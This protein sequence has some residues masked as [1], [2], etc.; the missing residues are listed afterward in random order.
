MKADDHDIASIF[1]QLPEERRAAMGELRQT[2]VANLPE[3]F[4]ESVNKSSIAYVV[5]LSV[6]PPGYH[7]NPKQPLPFIDISSAKKHIALYHMG[8]YASEELAKW[9]AEEYAKHTATTLDMGKGCVR[10][11]NTRQIPFSLIGQLCQRMSAVEWISLYEKIV[12]R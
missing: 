4:Q 12:K 10:F 8:L 5:P 1:D 11:K 2:I 6:Y 7:C 9:L 3:G